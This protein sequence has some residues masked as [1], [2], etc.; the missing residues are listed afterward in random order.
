MIKIPN[1]KQESIYVAVSKFIATFGSTV[2]TLTVD[3]GKEFSGYQ[4]LEK[5]F[6]IPIYFCHPYAPWE[7]GTNEYFNRKI[8]WFFPKKTNFT[9][10]TQDSITESIELINARPLK[11]L[12]GMTPIDKF[13]ELFFNRSD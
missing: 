8:R 2:K 6:G 5:Q 7:R 13:Y 1:R 9:Y 4:K 10:V 11:I 12:D 3:H